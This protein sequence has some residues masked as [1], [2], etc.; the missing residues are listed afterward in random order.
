MSSKIEIMRATICIVLLSFIIT[1]NAQTSSTRT[2]PRAYDVVV[3]GGTPAGVAAAIAAA[4]LG[5]R[6][7]IVEQSPV[8][9]GVLSSGVNRLDDYVVEANSGVIEDFRQRVKK[10]HLTELANDPVVKSDIQDPS[11]WSVADGRGWEPKTAA[12]IYAEMVAEVPG[13]ATRFGE[14]PVGVK[15]KG[16]RIVAVIT[17]D[18][19]NSG[20]LGAEH[21]YDGTIIVDATYEGDVAAFAGV[22]FRIGR[23]A[24]SKEEPHAGMIYTDAFCGVRS[25]AAMRGT[26]FPGS[27]GKGDN[28]TQAFTFRFNAKDY[29]RSD[30]PYRLKSPPPGYNP[31]KYDWNSNTKPW[32]PNGKS[33]MLGAGD[34]AG[35]STEYVLADWDRRAEMEQ[36][37]KNHELGWLYYIQTEGGS[38]QWGLSNDEFTD[39]GNWPYRLYVR[40]G[41]RIEG[42]YTLTESDLHKDL[43]GNGL[44]GPLQ[45][46]AIAIGTYPIDS[47][48]VQNPIDLDSP[49]GEGGLHLNDVTG[50]YQIPYGVMVPKN[51]NG[52]IVPVCI[53]ATHVAISSV[54]MEPV[55]SSL[56]QAAGVASALAVKSKQELSDVPVTDIQDALLDQGST[57]FFYKDLPAD[58]PAYEAVQK[59]SLLG[60]TDGDENYYFHPDQPVTLG[61]FARMAVMGLDI[62]LSITAAHFTDVPRSHPEFKFI[63]T[64]YDYST[65]SQ[66]EF[67][68]FEVRN[69]LNYWWGSKSFHG[70]PVYAYPDKAVTKKLAGEI[71]AGL[72]QGVS[73]ADADHP[74]AGALSKNMEGVFQKMEF[75]STIPD[76][77]ITRGEAARLIHQVR[78]QGDFSRQR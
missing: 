39:N 73:I 53:S 78:E 40:T 67:F 7:I 4:R 22:P 52:L 3:I 10:Y 71:I 68:S 41:R 43:R 76:G 47:H 66:E 61:E 13:I 21:R 56:G 5:M 48:N 72:A 24:R 30:H 64:L 29:G 33:D 74:L 14:V 77:I 8:L 42:Y 6:V 12:R 59:L 15:M 58:A 51:R 34:L 54:R 2:A 31:K 37:Y 50:P 38:P 20:R 46:D 63:E 26:I 32:L 19:D 23:E 44:R 65:Q 18:R 45:Q 35:L 11:R 57:I 16:D 9:G 75:S 28:R 25:S 36:I 17:R 49:C 62:P 55:Y 70:P 69:Y 60:A 1:A 27:T